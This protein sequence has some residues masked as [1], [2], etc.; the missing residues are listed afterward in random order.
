MENKP[1][2]PKKEPTLSKK[3]FNDVINNVMVLLC[4]SLITKCIEKGVPF[5]AKPQ[6]L[7]DGEK[8]KI[9]NPMFIRPKGARRHK[10]G[11]QTKQE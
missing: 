5:E 3:D 8:L 11:K 1:K 9:P 2:K 6:E 7:R 10:R 4:T